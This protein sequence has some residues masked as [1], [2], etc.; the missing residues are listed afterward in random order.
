MDKIGLI[1]VAGRG[2]RLNLPFSKELYPIRTNSYYPV[3]LN[4]I[5]ALKSIGIY[6]CVFVINPEKSDLLKYLGNGSKFSM[7]FQFVIHEVP[8]SLPQSIL[9]AVDLIRDKEVFFLLADSLISPDNYLSEFSRV[10]TKFPITLGLFKSS[11][12]DKFSMVKFNLKYV[13]DIVDK[14]SSNKYEHMWG[15]IRWNNEFTNYIRNFDFY[16]FHRENRNYE[17]TLTDVLM[18]FV[19]EKKVDYVLLDRFSFRDLGTYDE[20]EAY[21][22]EH[23]KK[24][25]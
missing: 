19:I 15:L 7:Q 10:D 8:K 21:M 2:S 1:P 16:Q 23:T 4:S 9:E 11:R 6:K 20:I 3:V 14:D 24:I 22:S 12:P 25:D 5:N 17:I 18:Y 13:T